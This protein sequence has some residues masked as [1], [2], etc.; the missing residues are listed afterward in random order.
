MLASL[1][2]Q[3]FADAGALP[4]HTDGIIDE[5][6]RIEEAQITILIREDAPGHW[7]A[8]M[9]SMGRDVASICRSFG[10]GGHEVAA[11]CELQGSADD[12][13]GAIL[14]ALEREADG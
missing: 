1:G 7:R 10:G 4:E 8:S 12:A 2:L 5:I 6:K 13:T 14:D 11:G 9:R 3:D